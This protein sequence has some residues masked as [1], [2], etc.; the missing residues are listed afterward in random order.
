M[1]HTYIANVWVSP[2][3]LLNV[4][5]VFFFFFFFS[6]MGGDDLGA[7]SCFFFILQLFIL[8]AISYTKLK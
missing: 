7:L 4:S 6:Q 3:V 5:Q 1:A 2:G 8:K